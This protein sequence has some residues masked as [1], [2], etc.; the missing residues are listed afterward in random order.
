M[1]FLSRMFTPRSARRAVHPGRAVR[2]AVTPRAVK[3][4]QRAVH[5]VDN[6]IYGVQRK[7]NT[8]RR[9]PGKKG[10]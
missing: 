2:R 10:R 5:P 9:K 4:A 1:G 6:A 8:K 7:L 3:R